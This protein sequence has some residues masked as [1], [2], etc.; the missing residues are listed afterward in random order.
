MPGDGAAALDLGAHGGGELAKFLGFLFGEVGCFEGVGLEVKEFP[1]GVGSV[2]DELPG[3]A[4]HGPGGVAHV[5]E[6]A[7]AAGE[8]G[9]A[10]EGSLGAGFEEGEDGAAFDIWW[11]SSSG[12]LDGGGE[13]V[14]GEEGEVAL[15][16][17]FDG[18]G[19][20]GGGGDFEATFIHVLFAAAE[21]A[22]VGADV[23][24]ASVI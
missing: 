2:F 7:L 17:G 9:V 18:A 22:A 19:P 1:W 16:S 12:G 10:L 14:H 5:A 6:V 13:E 3:A 8:E 15:G 21:V 23:E 4:A 24:L 11:G 20:G